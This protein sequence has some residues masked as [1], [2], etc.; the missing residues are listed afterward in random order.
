MKRARGL[1]FPQMRLPLSYHA[2]NAKLNSASAEEYQWKMHTLAAILM[3]AAT[4][5]RRGPSAD[6]VVVQILRRAVLFLSATPLK[7]EV[8]N[9]DYTLTSWAPLGPG[10]LAGLPPVETDRSSRN[11]YHSLY[12]LRLNTLKTRS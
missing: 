7:P 11:K 4:I 1:L 10:A 8:L 5:G 12:S 3:M 6:F 9:D 2:C